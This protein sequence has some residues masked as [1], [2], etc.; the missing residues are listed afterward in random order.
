MLYSIGYTETTH[1][2]SNWEFE[3]IGSIST[4]LTIKMKRVDN[5]QCPESKIQRKIQNIE[6]RLR[7]IEA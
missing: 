2:T 3:T 7:A 6:L 1:E 5:E 4:E